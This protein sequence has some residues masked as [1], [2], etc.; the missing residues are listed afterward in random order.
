MEGAH[1]RAVDDAQKHPPARLDLDDLG[2]G[3]RAEIG[4]ERVIFDV[5]EVWPRRAL[6]SP[7][8]CSTREAM[9]PGRLTH[10]GHR[11]ER[12]KIFKDLLGRREAEIGQHHE[13]LPARPTGRARRG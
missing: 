12:R 10:G 13:Q 6:I 11:V 8:S 1:R 9:A 2:V 4:E 7:S 5:V 3:E